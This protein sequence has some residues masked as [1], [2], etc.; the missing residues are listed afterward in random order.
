MKILK[1]VAFALGII[2]ALLLLVSLFLPSTF[3][4]ERSATINAQPDSVYALIADLKNWPQWSPWQKADATMKMT[5]SANTYGV[6]AWQEWQGKD[7]DGKLTILAA[8][9]P[10]MVKYEFAMK[11]WGNASTGTLNLTP[12]GNAT[13][14]VWAMEGDMGMNPID[15]YFGLMMDKFVGPD[16]EKGLKNLEEA[17][18]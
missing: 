11:D 1:R 14:V 10:K 16:F 13:K 2:I 18:K 8:E 17:A 15:K 6:G 5:Y 9:Q 4:V 7:G 12:E 3:K